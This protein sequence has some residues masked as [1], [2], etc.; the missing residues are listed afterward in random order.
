MTSVDVR[1]KTKC[2]KK[3]KCKKEKKGKKRM[4]NSS[5]R[6]GESVEKRK[7]TTSGKEQ[8]IKKNFSSTRCK[9]EIQFII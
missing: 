6:K 8:R 5:P 9:A 7:P 2:E 4:L 1:A 3:E